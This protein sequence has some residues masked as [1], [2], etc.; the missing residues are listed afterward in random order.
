MTNIIL[1]NSLTS[2]GDR[3]F[4]S[5]RSLTSVRIPDSVTNLGYHAFVVCRSLGNVQVGNGVTHLTQNA[6]GGCVVLTT[7]I[8]GNQVTNIDGG[9]FW[10]CG[11]LAG[12]YFKGN[13]PATDANTFARAL[14]AT[15]YY[16]PGTTGWGPPFG[17]RPTALWQPQVQTRDGS[18]GMRTNRFGFNIA[19]ASGMIVVV[20]TCTNLTNP[21]WSPLQTNTLAGDSFYFSDPAWTNYSRRFYRL[22][23]P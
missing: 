1:P 21:L 3:A 2:I 13:A 11:N 4:A 17:G 5:C 9:A 15:V 8:I 16:L 22:R 12:I 18:F 19:W 6:F 10:D 23:S 7:V 14:N 20:E